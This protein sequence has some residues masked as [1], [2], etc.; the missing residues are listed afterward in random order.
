MRIR[1]RIKERQLR[2][3]KELAQ[4][5][6]LVYDKMVQRQDLEVEFVEKKLKEDTDLT[7]KQIEQVMKIITIGS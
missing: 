2:R 7:K 6:D 4:K 5:L 3:Q 1:E